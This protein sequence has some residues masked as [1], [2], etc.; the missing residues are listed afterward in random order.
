M[1][2]A[3]IGSN[4]PALDGL[5][6]VSILAVIGFHGD[7]PGFSGG[8]RGV[9]LFYVISGYL[10]AWLLLKEKE[11][12]GA[13]SLKKFYYRRMLRILPAF[14][15]FLAGYW[16]ICQIFFT[17]LRKDLHESMLIAGTYSTNFMMGWFNRNVLMAHTWSL[18]LEEQFYL[19][20]PA[21]IAFLSRRQATFMAALVVVATPLY[22][23]AIYHPT[24]LD[25]L[26]LR[27]A[28]SP[29]TRFD[30]II[31]GC[32]IALI[33]RDEKG[34]Q[35][36][37]AIFCRP[38]TVAAAVLVMAVNC[39]FSSISKG[40]M[41]TAGYSLSAASFSFLLL[42][43]L[44]REDHFLNKLMSVKPMQVTGRLS[45]ALYLWHPA[46]LG[47]SSKIVHKLHLPAQPVSEVCLYL[48]LSFSLAAASY[49]IIEQPFLRLKDKFTLVGAA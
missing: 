9:D 42:F 43:I 48:L 21:M 7:W 26:P 14:Y 13:V 32:L 20:F 22:R 12:Y 6:G 45:Y 8:G 46:A 35:W 34:K 3:K 41:A 44:V 23:L 10:I 37:E 31:W 11:K 25:R 39:Y 15:A 4:I 33:M 36:L 27:F 1:K 47:I 28:Y 17:D 24:L 30:T 29:D 19:F 49:W 16:I 40:F 2:N 5:R 38:V 18:S